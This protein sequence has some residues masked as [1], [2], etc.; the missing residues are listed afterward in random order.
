MGKNKIIGWDLP[1]LKPIREKDLLPV[2]KLADAA[3]EYI[4]DLENCT[5]RNNEQ[6]SD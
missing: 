6:V 3:R 4:K 2:K 1:S 5:E